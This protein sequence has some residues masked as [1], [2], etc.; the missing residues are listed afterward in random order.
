MP[1]VSD[2]LRN[3]AEL[4]HVRHQAL[5]RAIDQPHS[6]YRRPVLVRHVID[7]LMG[8][9]AVVLQPDRIW[10]ATEEEKVAFFSLMAPSLPR[11]RLPHVIVGQGAG[12]RLRLFPDNQPVGGT[13]NGRVVFTYLVTA[14]ETEALRAFVQHHADVL[15]A[16]PGWALRVGLPQPL[17]DATAHFEGAVRDELTPLR[18]ELL[19]KL[20]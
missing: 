10:L 17:A 9:D 19:A 11:E 5:Y 12:G 8:L 6:R 7:R 20:K 3:R 13:T 14:W 1:T 15:R 18:P 16:L 4:Y 2:C